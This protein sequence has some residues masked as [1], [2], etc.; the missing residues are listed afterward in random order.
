MENRGKKGENYRIGE[1]SLGTE[2]TTRG[3]ETTSGK[4][5]NDEENANHQFSPLEN[6]G[7][8]IWMKGMRVGY[9][10]RAGQRSFTVM[11]SS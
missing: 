3:R 4:R 8:G 7:C 1:T 2:K 10:E 5:E 6:E 11:L 9:N